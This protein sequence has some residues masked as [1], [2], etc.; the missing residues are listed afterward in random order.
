MRI[1]VMGTGPFAVPSAEKLLE[2]GHKIELV[3]TRPIV[4]SDPKKR[5]PAPIFDWAQRHGLPI[6]QPDSINSAE[7]IA[8]LNQFHVDLFFVCDYGQILSRSCLAASRLGGINLHGS[9]LPRHRGAAPVQW[10]IL[11]GDKIAGVSV[12]H[13][14]PKL[15]GG[16][17]VSSASTEILPDEDAG[18]LEA[19]LARLGVEATRQ[20][21]NE[22]QNWDG[23]SG[24]GTLQDA[25]HATKA[26]R[27]SKSDGQLDFR[28][29]ANYLVRLVRAL[30]P[31]PGTFAEIC[32]AG[33]KHTRLIV[34]AARYADYNQF[35]TQADV[36]AAKATATVGVKVSA[37]A[38]LPIGSIWPTTARELGLNW[39]E[40]WQRLVAVK[41][42]AGILLIGRLQPSGKRDMSAEEFLRGHPLGS[43]ESFLLPSTVCK[44]L[45][46]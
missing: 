42:S 31:W 24:I 1:M 2:D 14:T 30:Q 12:I 44:R 19:R 7:A 29:P 10:T 11:S 15:D 38:E 21:V 20:T 34:R 8:R 32:R 17:I 37:A 16:P 43:G 41:C 3:V 23:H 40:P 13:M 35:A 33:G 46:D 22:L 9:L 45:A 39:D 27:F 18:H 28:L 26:P 6:Y 5:P 36:A 25:A 4:D